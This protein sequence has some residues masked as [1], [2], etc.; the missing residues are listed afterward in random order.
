METKRL[1]KQT[2]QPSKPPRCRVTRRF[3]T[4]RT[5]REAVKNLLRAHAEK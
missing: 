5:S 4:N 1:V 3:G 2:L